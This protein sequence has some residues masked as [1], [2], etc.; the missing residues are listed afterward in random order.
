MSRL[1]FLLLIVSIFC[2]DY[3][4]E[5]MNETVSEEYCNNVIGNMTALINEGYVYLDFFKAPKQPN[6]NYFPKMDLIK[7]LNNINRTNRTF[8]EFYGDIHEIIGNT[9][10]GHFS[11]LS[12][13]TPNNISL[14]S[15]YFCIPFHFFVKEVF[16]I[17]NVTLN[18]TY[19]TI[20][21]IPVKTY[22]REHFTNDTISEIQKLS[23]K[24]IISINNMNP[25]DYLEKATKNVASAHSKQ[26][27]FVQSINS[28]Y[29]QIAYIYPHK[30]EDL[31]I[32]IKFEG[33]E[34]LFETYI[35]LKK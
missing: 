35:H 17:D 33:E 28:I 20:D 31:N 6:P 21:L 32:S 26:C 2:Q 12:E 5:L 23:G 25:Y 14:Y 8:Y 9:G 27:K 29:Q 19:L 7:E 10:D 1:L 16:D 11:F 30:K 22:C 13:A 34:K 3:Y 24:K 18:D 4:D 15:Y